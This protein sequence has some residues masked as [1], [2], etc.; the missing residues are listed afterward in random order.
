MKLKLVT[1]VAVLCSCGSCG[2]STPPASIDTPTVERELVSSSPFLFVTLLGPHTGGMTATSEAFHVADDGLV[3]V[4]VESTGGTLRKIRRARLSTRAFF[5]AVAR[6]PSS[7]MDDPK[8]GGAPGELTDFYPAQV[9]LAWLTAA[10]E[11]RIQSFRREDLSTRLSD[12]V[13]RVTALRQTESLVEAESGLYVRA[14]RIPGFDPRV[15]T[16]DLVLQPEE[17]QQDPRLSEALQREMGL[18]RIGGHGD[19]VRVTGGLELRPRR[20]VH[21][22]VGD[23]VY[24]FITFATIDN[25]SKEAKK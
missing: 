21:I 9:A 17:A 7:E 8:P 3:Q 4:S 24:R 11:Y 22:Q 14:Q 15:Q 6:I 1:I 16:A 19:T 5:E 12:L 20:P 13:E 2:G 23:V 18:V 25:T 10:G